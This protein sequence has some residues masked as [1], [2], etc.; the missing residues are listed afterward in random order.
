MAVK[1][2]LMGFGR[3]GRNVFRLL[4]RSDEFRIAAISDIA[5]PEALVYLLRYDTILGRFPDLVTYR[6]GYFYTWGREFPLLA[7][8]DPGDV[9]WSERGVDYV[10]EA[11]GR[12]RSRAEMEKHLAGGARRVIL[13]VPPKDHPDISVVYGVNHDQLRPG[14]RIIS[15]ASCTAHCAA[16]VLA[17]LHDAFGIERAHLTSI[18]AYNSTQRLAEVPAEDMRQ[19][20]AAAENIVPSDTKAAG[21]LSEVLPALAGRLSASALR[22]PV[23]NGSIV[24]MTIWMERKISRDGVN[25]V[26]RTAAAGPYR[27]ILEYMQDPIVSS[28]VLQSPY[29]STFDSLA[30]MTLGDRLVK[31]IAWFDNSWGYANRVVDLLRTLSAP[32][33]PE[34]EEA[35]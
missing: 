8:K 24:D 26:L 22:V 28:D 32:Y 31:V 10:V 11:T 33:G 21:L 19:S 13:C 9:S 23:A 30:T 34:R 17:A 27:E 35:R 16:P 4:Y 25:E 7:A 20:R 14:H 29:S 15:N 18:H 12:Q 2:G 1:I 3:I 6:D 5:D